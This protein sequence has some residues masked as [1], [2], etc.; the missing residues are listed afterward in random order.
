MSGKTLFLILFYVSAVC[1]IYAQYGGTSAPMEGW[2]FS[3]VIGPTLNGRYFSVDEYAES[4]RE[5]DGYAIVQGKSTYFFLYDT[6]TYH[7]GDGG[8]IINRVIPSWVE[9]MGYVIDFDNIKEYK[10]NQ[11]LASSVRALMQQRGCD[12]SVTLVMGKSVVGYDY[13]QINIRDKKTGS[14]KSIIY[15]LYYT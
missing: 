15:P 6:N 5:Q 2:K 10:P 12:I 13:V 11:N 14:Y 9:K 7:D 4:Y 8:D 3:G 1:G